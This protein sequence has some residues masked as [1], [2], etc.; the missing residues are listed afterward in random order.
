VY[1]PN[2]QEIQ[3]LESF[4]TG[5]YLGGGCGGLYKHKNPDCMEPIP[6]MADHKEGLFTLASA[7]PLQWQT[8]DIEY[9]VKADDKAKALLT[10]YHNGMKIHDAVELKHKPGQFYFQDHRNPVRYRNIW[11]LE[12][13]SEN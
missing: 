3:V 1:L 10:V 5:T 9:R 4:G 6:S 12:R 11:V 2:R 7:P 8:Y 13:P